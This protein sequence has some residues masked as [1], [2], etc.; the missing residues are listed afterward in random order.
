MWFL[1]KCVL[2]AL[3]LVVTNSTGV[4]LETVGT[5]ATRSRNEA[6][7]ITNILNVAAF[8]SLSVSATTY[9]ESL[10]L[11]PQGDEHRAFVANHVAN[12]ISRFKSLS[13]PVCSTG[14][15]DLE[16]APLQDLIV[17]MTSKLIKFPQNLKE[18]LEESVVSGGFEV[19]SGIFLFVLHYNVT[20]THAKLQVKTLI[21]KAKIAPFFYIQRYQKAYANAIRSSFRSEDSIQVLGT[22]WS[23][24][25]YRLVHQ[26]VNTLNTL[27]FSK[28]LPVSSD[29]KISKISDYTI[30][31]LQPTF[32]VK[33]SAK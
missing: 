27:L 19:E 30:S 9:S 20:D 17:S 32:S 1:I 15:D 13:G 6:T 22:L 24:E 7:T 3:C 31:P 11:T 29:I 4:G 25:H 18:D 28:P 33:L 10:D 21:L 26:V 14:F 8:K 2:L 16:C 23:E 12:K 5:L